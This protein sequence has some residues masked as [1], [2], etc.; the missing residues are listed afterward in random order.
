MLESLRTPL[1]ILPKGH[2]TFYQN[3]TEASNMLSSEERGLARS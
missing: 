2:A 3:L 1:R